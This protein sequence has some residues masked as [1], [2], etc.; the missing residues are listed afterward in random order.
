MTFQPVLPFGGYAGW[1]FLTR[2]LP[3]QKAAFDKSPQLEREITYFQEKIGAISSPEE[4]VAD[5]TLLK[6][7]LGAFGLDS[8]ISN[9]F[10][11]RKVLESGS[12]NEK[13]LA[14]RLADKRYLEFSAAFGFGDFA[15]PRSASSSFGSKITTLYRAR[16]FEIA[17]GN[18]DEHMRLALGFKRSIGD[19]ASRASSENT[20][21]FTIL[22]TAPLRQVFEKAFGLPASFGTLD[23]DQQ[24]SVMKEKA[25]ALLGTPGVTQFSDPNA[26]DKL[27]RQFLVRVE[28]Q[29]VIAQS[30]RGQVALSLLQNSALSYGSIIPNRI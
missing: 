7:A 23:L 16:Q 10:F 19:L 20:K 30:A 13:G 6:V 1:A 5:R 12:L 11:I 9:K 3:T 14:N 22:G 18:Q 27:I 28:S 26:Q 24:L 8:D 29:S 2:T 17:V 25:S 21:W 4:L 15:V